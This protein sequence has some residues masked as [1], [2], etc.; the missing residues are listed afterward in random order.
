MSEN[1]I[2]LDNASFKQEVEDYDGMVLIDFWAPWCGPCRAIGPMIEELAK[3]Y[4]GK[5]KVGK[6]N[7]DENNDLA[8]QFSIKSIPTI[9]IFSRG[10]VKESIVGAVPK[11]KLV[12]AINRASR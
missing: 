3:E 11:T 8:M 9:L 12:D 5:L 4:K 2:Q 6:I 1:I 10:S 7:V